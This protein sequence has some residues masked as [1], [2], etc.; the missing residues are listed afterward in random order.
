MTLAQE[1]R[2][3]I[4]A[5]VGTALFAAVYEFFSHQVYSMFMLLAFLV[6][7]L[8]GVLPLSLL[9]GT[10]EKKH[11]G[12]LCRCLYGSAVAVLTVGCIFRGILEIYGTTSYLGIFYWIAG[13]MLLL[14]ALVLYA[15]QLKRTL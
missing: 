2:M 6:P 10:D 11:P 8:G 13:A 7:L 3:Y 1:K 14:P 5:A 15:V 9:A 12:I 4:T